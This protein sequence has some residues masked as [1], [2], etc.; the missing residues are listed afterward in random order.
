MKSNVGIINEDKDKSSLYFY[1]AT[2]IVFMFLFYKLISIGLIRGNSKKVI[3]DSAFSGVLIKKESEGNDVF[4]LF[5]KD[6][7]YWLI[8]SS[9]NY[10]YEKPYLEEFLEKGDSISKNKCSDT[11]YIKRKHHLFYFIIGDRL[12]NDPSR[13]ENFRKYWSD[14]R[15]ILTENNNCK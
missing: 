12:Y 7:M 3:M 11:L 9:S 14:R 13:D 4:V 8:N 5:E 2:A 15:S 10:L 1:V 6:S